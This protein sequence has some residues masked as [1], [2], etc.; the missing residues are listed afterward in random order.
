MRWETRGIVVGDT[1]QVIHAG[2]FPLI[3]VIR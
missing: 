3:S 1:F 2:A